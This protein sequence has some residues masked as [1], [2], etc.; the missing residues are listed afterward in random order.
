MSFVFQRNA[1]LFGKSSIKIGAG[2]SWETGGERSLKLN[3]ETVTNPIIC[4]ILSKK[5]R[6][7]SIEQ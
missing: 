2:G 6:T 5:S 1:T 7:D 4:E 3:Y